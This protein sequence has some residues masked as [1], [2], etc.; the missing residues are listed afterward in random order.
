MPAPDIQ[1]A[2]ARRLIW[3]ALEGLLPPQRASLADWT[4]GHRQLNNQ[5]GGYV[6]QW[7]HSEA[8]YLAEPME[9]LSGDRHL[10]VG[11]VGPGQSGKTE[12]G[13]NYLLWSAATNPANMLWYMQTDEALEAHVKSKLDPML[14]L[15]EGIHA[16]LGTA[17]GDDT[18]HFK[19]FG[20][21]SVQLLAAT[22]ANLISKSAPRIVVDEVDAYTA[23]LGNVKA[24]LD[25]RRQTFGRMSKLLMVSH[26]DKATGLNPERD[27]NAGIMAVYKDSDR[28]TWWW[29]CPHCNG[30]SSPNPNAALRMRLDYPEKAPLD[31][32]QDAARLICP[33][34]GK[35][36]EDRW[37]RAMLGTGRWLRRGE[38]VDQRGVIQGEAAHHD[39]A[40][41]WIMG[42]MSPFVLGGIG[43]LARAHAAAVRDFE[44]SGDENT[45]RQVVC[46]QLGQPHEKPRQVGEVDA[47]ALADRA[48]PSLRL[49]EVPEGVRWYT[50]AADTQKGRWDVLW[51]G[52]GVDGESWVMDHRQITD[53]D[54]DTSPEDWQR[55]FE[56]MLTP[57]P[58]ADGSG[59][60]MRPR[61]CVFD[62]YGQAGVTERAYEAW[63][64][65]RRDGL[66]K[67]L[68]LI[69]GRDAWSLLASKG[70]PG[71][72][73]RLQVTYPDARADR[74]AAARGQVPV[75]GFSTNLAKDALA[76]Q[77]RR[78]LPGAGY[79]H[80]P[81]GVTDRQ[82]D[83]FEQLTAESRSKAGAWDLRVEG[84]RNEVTDL[85][86]A[87]HAAARLHGLRRLNWA[88]PPAWAAEWDQNSMVALPAP[89]EPEGETAVA[90][91]PL[92]AVVAAQ[93]RPSVGLSPGQARARRY[94]T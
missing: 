69:D 48:A 15:H 59:R 79:V 4:A 9:C 77:L 49:G 33:C 25:L 86:V 6:G 21:M 29:Q 18:L 80:I 31:E 22:S 82:S 92:S 11:V 71:F 19:R 52:W 75:M 16:K 30:H 20:S 66:A 89:A 65:A 64:K 23:K 90:Q 83:W 35:G 28:R 39:T 81:A 76:G 74:R 44:A 7:Q 27:W 8:P 60:V 5:G 37:R 10:T 85:M 51:R 1:F 36:I 43:A 61:C 62:A 50:V 70:E 13:H 54:P 42:V 56:V 78:A 88:K 93:A 53:V 63:I 24:L 94:A 40:G 84:T 47:Q 2:S 91:A 26:P 38:V 67:R 14:L 41:F 57:L 73:G 17:P 72:T 58:L 87:A 45:L 32:V 34:C 46:K 12:I 3:E 68:G 55:L